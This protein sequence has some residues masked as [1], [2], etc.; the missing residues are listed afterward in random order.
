MSQNIEKL[1][2]IMEQPTIAPVSVFKPRIFF[3]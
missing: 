1:T 2:F 3:F